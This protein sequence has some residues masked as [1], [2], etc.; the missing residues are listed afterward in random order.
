MKRSGRRGG[1]KNASG[2]QEANEEEEFHVNE[3]VKEASS[4]GATPNK[5]LRS[6]KK[7]ASSFDSNESDSSD[8]NGSDDD[9][10]FGKKKY[11]ARKHKERDSEQPY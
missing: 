10:Q 5:N 11:S 6:R 3:T 9:F 1:S 2:V 4:H 8:D 7:S